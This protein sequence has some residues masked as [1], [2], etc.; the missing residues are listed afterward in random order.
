MQSADLDQKAR[1]ASSDL[2]LHCCQCPSP[3]STDNPLYTGIWRHSNNNS[4]AINNRFIT[5]VNDNHIDNYL[6]EIMAFVHYGSIVNNRPKKHLIWNYDWNQKLTQQIFWKKPLSLS[7]IQTGLFT[8]KGGFCF[9]C[10]EK[11][12]QTTFWN[13]VFLIKY[14]LTFHAWHVGSY[15]LKRI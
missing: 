1:S 2:D 6:K 4:A 14:D 9:P 13:K 15:F 10:W 5:L 12:Q 8:T 7:K 11:N 3:G